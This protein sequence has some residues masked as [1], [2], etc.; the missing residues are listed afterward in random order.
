MIKTATLIGAGNVA[1]HMGK[2][3]SVSGV[4]IAQIYSRNWQRANYLSSQL[5]SEAISD[6]EALKPAGIYILAVSDQAIPEVAAAI[7]SYIPAD[8]LVVHTSGGTPSAFLAAHFQRYGVFYPLQTFTAG[9][10]IAFR[11]APLC[12]HAGSEADLAAL[13]Q[14]GSRIS[15]RVYR[16]DDQ[17]RQWLHVMAVAVNNFPNHLYTLAAEV[18]TDHNLSF[19]LLRPLILETA[20]KVQEASPGPMQTGP[21]IRG[22]RATIAAHLHLLDE[23]PQLKELYAVITKSIMNE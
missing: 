19:D 22:D 5:S 20:R 12:I 3:L 15:A 18:L 21:A 13:E 11:E 7:S 2:A 17:Q 14:L 1:Q 6:F 16:I 23:Y 8:S 10:E 9:R 4:E